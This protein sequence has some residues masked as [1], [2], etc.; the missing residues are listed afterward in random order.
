VTP[1]KIPVADVLALCGGPSGPDDRA[2]K[3][4]A[5]HPV[6]CSTSGEKNPHTSMAVFARQPSAIAK[7]ST[8][9]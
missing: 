2:S 9:L 3:E 8:R 4:Y 7:E 5:Q 6:D 1:I